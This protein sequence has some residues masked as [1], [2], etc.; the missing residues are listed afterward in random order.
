[1]A[2]KPQLELYEFEEILGDFGPFDSV[3]RTKV[4]EDSSIVDQDDSLAY[5]EGLEIETLANSAIHF[6]A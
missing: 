3:R 2:R 4:N 6:V 1:L 5:R